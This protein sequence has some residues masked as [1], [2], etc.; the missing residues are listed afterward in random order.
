MAWNEAIQV[1]LRWWRHSNDFVIAGRYYCDMTLSLKAALP[2]TERIATASDRCSKTG[3]WLPVCGIQRSPVDSPHDAEL[4]YPFVGLLILLKTVELPVIRDAMASMWRCANL[5]TTLLKCVFV[6]KDVWI[7]NKIS[8]KYVPGQINDKLSL[9]QVM[10][11]CRLV[12]K[13]RR[14]FH[15]WYLYRSTSSVE[16]SLCLTVKFIKNVMIDFMKDSILVLYV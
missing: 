6:N 5:W 11:W 16:R 12:L 4:W 14:P 15:V 1:S 3:P 2:L 10:T 13:W 7:S 9:I 8:S